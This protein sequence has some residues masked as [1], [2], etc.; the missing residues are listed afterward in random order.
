MRRRSSRP[1]ERHKGVTHTAS[2]LK[3]RACCPSG[4]GFGEL[5]LRVAPGGRF[6]GRGLQSSTALN[7]VKSLETGSERANSISRRQYEDRAKLIAKSM[8]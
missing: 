3:A 5:L 6:A 2:D 4:C 8:S 7:V 1:A